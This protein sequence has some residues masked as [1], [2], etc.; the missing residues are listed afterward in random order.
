F[1]IIL[2]GPSGLTLVLAKTR[3]RN[4][5]V[6]VAIRS[7][8]KCPRKCPTTGPSCPLRARLPTRAPVLSAV[9]ANREAFAAVSRASG[10]AGRERAFAR[11][12]RN[13]RDRRGPAHAAFRADRRPGAR[14]LRRGPDR[15]LARG[16]R[17]P[18]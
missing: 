2:S 18:S 16:A 1:V 5:G 7:E 9:I 8:R 4:P 12:G 14:H 11:P 17:N 15:H 10:R 3:H 6:S 13:G